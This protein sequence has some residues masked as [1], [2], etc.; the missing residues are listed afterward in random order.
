[1]RM[2]YNVLSAHLR[3]EPHATFELGF[4]FGKHLRLE[5]PETKPIR[6]VP[7]YSHSTGQTPLFDRVQVGPN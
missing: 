6:A 7:L 3:S 5:E 1:M 2:K 4:H